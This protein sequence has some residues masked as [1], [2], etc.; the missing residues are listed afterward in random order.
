MTEPIRDQTISIRLTAVEHQEIVQA[1]KMSGETASAWCRDVILRLAR[2]KRVEVSTDK[3][4]WLRDAIAGLA[5]LN[6]EHDSPALELQRREAAERK[7]QV[8]LQKLGL[9]SSP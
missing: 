1:A 8:A 4:E 6:T 5:K 9:D 2:G 7:L 3:L